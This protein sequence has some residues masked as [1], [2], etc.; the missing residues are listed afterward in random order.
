MEGID[1]QMI[2]EAVKKTKSPKQALNGAKFLYEESSTYSE[3]FKACFE[4]AWKDATKRNRAIERSQ[5]KLSDVMWKPRIHLTEE[6]VKLRANK[7]MKSSNPTKEWGLVLS[8]VDSEGI[9]QVF[10]LVND[11]RKSLNG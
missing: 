5:G 1:K 4:E 2:I 3:V 8:E 9:R 11:S 6:E 7:I 10:Q